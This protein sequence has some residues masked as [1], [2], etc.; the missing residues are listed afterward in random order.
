MQHTKL[1]EELTVCCIVFYAF[2][3]SHPIS[4]KVDSFL[5]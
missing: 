5:S 4:I 1:L 2:K 3:N